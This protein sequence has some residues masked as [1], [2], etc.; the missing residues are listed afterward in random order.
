M[1]FQEYSTIFFTFIIGY[2]IKGN[3]LF[4]DN[5][6]A[7][8][9]LKNG[10]ASSGQK[11]KHMDAR[12]FF[13]KDR[14]ESEGIEIK[15]CPTEIMIADFFTKLLQGNLFRKFRDV[16]LG[17]VHIRTLFHDD[18]QS[19]SQERVSKESMEGH[20][21]ELNDTH[22]RHVDKDEETAESG[23]LSKKVTWKDIVRGEKKFMSV[24]N[25]TH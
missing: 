11:T 1:S 5:Q 24:K 23:P 6:A 7:M 3:T 21:E 13:I 18:E 20:S 19:S 10:K 4:Q 22:Q 8:R 16:I 14:C 2:K 12:Y 15:Y 9:I 25:N 17:Y